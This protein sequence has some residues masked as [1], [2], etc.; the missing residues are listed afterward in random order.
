MRVSPADFEHT[1]RPVIDM[2]TGWGWHTQ[3]WG[4]ETITEPIRLIL[5]RTEN[6]LRHIGDIIAARP[7]GQCVQC[8]QSHGDLVCHIDVKSTTRSY[9]RQTG[10]LTLE[11]RSWMALRDETRTQIPAIFTFEPFADCPVDYLRWIP[12]VR[13]DAHEM[14]VGP[15]TGNGSGDPYWLLPN[16]M[17]RKISTL[18]CW[19]GWS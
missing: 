15:H 2:M 12:A 6:G 5:G 16:G 9:D 17:A 8:H 14:V 10:R 18:R 13:L 1:V 11:M 3:Q 4:Q 19:D 7:N